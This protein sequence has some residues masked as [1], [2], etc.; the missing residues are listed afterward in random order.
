MNPSLRID[1]DDPYSE[2]DGQPMADSTE[3]YECIVKIKEN[4]EMLFADRA[5]VFIAGA[6]LWYPVPDRRETGPIAP[7][8]LVAFG[9]PK[10][11]RGSCRQ[12]DEDGIPP[13]V[14][15]EVISPSKTA[16]RRWQTSWPFMTCTA[17]RSTTSMTLKR[18]AS[19]SG[20]GVGPKTAGHDW[21][22]SRMSEA[23]PVRVWGCALP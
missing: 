6:L 23:G 22:P 17:S 14:F 8:V 9:R 21:P 19:R 5:D 11:R 3:Q 16:P 1:P 7:D 10:G 4:L 13:Q 2:S 20:R 18:T 12:W 15:F